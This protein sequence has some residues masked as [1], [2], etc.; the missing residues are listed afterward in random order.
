MSRLDPD[1]LWFM[2]KETTI[3]ILLAP[4]ALVSWLWAKV[5]GGE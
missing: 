1:Y 3:V 2:V 5:R 4:L